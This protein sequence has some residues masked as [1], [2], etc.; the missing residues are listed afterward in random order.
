MFKIEIDDK[1]VMGFLDR[2]EHAGQDMSPVMRAIRTELLSQTEANL[3]AEGKPKWQPLKP[4]TIAARTKSGSWPGMIMQVSGQLAASY[5]PG[6]DAVS[7]WIGSNKKY[8]AIQNLGGKIKHKGG[9]RYVKSASHKARFINNDFVGPVHGITGAH[10]I[11]IPARPSLPITPA[12]NLQPQTADAVLRLLTGH[13][14]ATA[15]GS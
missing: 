6:S 4:S 13:F 8:A 7:A 12:G 10:D 15:A 2:L 14:G 5:T 3:A 11:D 9:T 1:S